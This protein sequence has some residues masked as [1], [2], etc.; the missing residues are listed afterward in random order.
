MKA[1]YE[2]ITQPSGGSFRFYTYTKKEFDTPWHYHPE[3]ELT[4]ILASSGVRYVGDHFEN[5]EANDLVLLGPSVPHCWKNTGKQIDKA[6]AIVI[7]WE[8]HLLG[9]GW[10]QKFEFENIARLFQLA[11]QGIKFSRDI[12]L[13]MKPRLAELQELEPFERLIGLMKILNELAATKKRELL[14]SDGFHEKLNLKDYKRI[15]AI[16]N[17]VRTNYDKKITLEKTSSVVH[18]TSESFSRFFS[19]IMSKPFFTFLNEYRINMASKMLIESDFQV[20]EVCYNCGFESLP[21]FYRQFK[22]FKG[23]SPFQYRKAYQ[24]LKTLST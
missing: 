22:K 18:M 16:Y 10:Q 5:F 4:Y 20:A 13:S 23:S 6:S 24:T 11:R 19:K 3:Y 15:N 21:F 9:S 7:H 8:E 14:C 1:I 17:F 12:S 2:K